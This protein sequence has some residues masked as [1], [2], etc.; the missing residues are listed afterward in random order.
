MFFSSA[1]ASLNRESLES[2]AMGVQR[3]LFTQIIASVQLSKFRPVANPVHIHQLID[4]ESQMFYRF[5]L[6]FLV[7]AVVLCPNA[8]G[9]KVDMS[10]KELRQTATDVVVGKVV[11]VY[12]RTEAEGD[13]N[14][15][16][17]IAEIRVNAVEKGEAVEPDGLVYV[18]YWKRRWVGGGRGPTSTSG[19][20]GL[21]REG[22]TLRVYLAQNA[23]DGF[24]RTN[25]DGGFN[26]IGAN[27]FEKIEVKPNK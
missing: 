15:T 22:A 13:W 23:Y 5:S 16:R 3:G 21:P 11:R 17:F 12:E 1:S 14:Y 4:L 25:E 19:H 18:R 27:G 9:E 20:R 2:E 26:V 24:T 10:P 6:L 7:T 8:R